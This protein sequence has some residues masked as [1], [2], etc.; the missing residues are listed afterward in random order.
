MKY[1]KSDGISL[2]GLDYKKSIVYVFIVF[3]TLFLTL[4]EVSPHL[5]QILVAKAERGRTLANPSE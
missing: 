2:L 3:S 1:S 4:K 5:I